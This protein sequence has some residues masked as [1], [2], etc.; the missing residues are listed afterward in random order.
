MIIMTSFRT[1]T[2]LEMQTYVHLSDMQLGHIAYLTGTACIYK[3]LICVIV[4]VWISAYFLLLL[5]IIILH[6]ANDICQYSFHI[7]EWNTAAFES[8]SS[9]PLPIGVSS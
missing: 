7:L 2:Y 8:S 6:L 4:I 1:N 9:L 3:K 5:L